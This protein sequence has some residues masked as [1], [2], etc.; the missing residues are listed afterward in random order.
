MFHHVVDLMREALML[1]CDN[2]AYAVYNVLKKVNLK[3]NVP[4][5]NF[6]VFKSLTLRFFLCITTQFCRKKVE[7]KEN[8]LRHTNSCCNGK[9]E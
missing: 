9:K 6:H 7:D 4:F 3:F 1:R 8:L 2:N 5:F